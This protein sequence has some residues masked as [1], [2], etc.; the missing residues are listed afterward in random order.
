MHENQ[1]TETAYPAR[2][3]YVNQA[4]VQKHFQQF[5]F[6]NLRYIIF[7]LYL[8]CIAFLHLHF[9]CIYDFLFLHFLSAVAFVCIFKI[10][11][12]ALHAAFFSRFKISKISPQAANTNQTL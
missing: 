12:F 8:F 5:V 11:F 4:D 10:H 2:P 9:L 1:A 3:L 7:D 6:L